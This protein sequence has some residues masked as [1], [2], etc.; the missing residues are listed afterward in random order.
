VHTCGKALAS[1]GAFVAGS[2][3]L[4]RFLI[5][6][7]R[8]FIFSTALPPYLAFQVRAAVN[9]AASMDAERRYLSAMAAQLR[10]K[11]RSLGFDHGRSGSHIVPLMVPGNQAALDMALALRERGCAVRAIRPPTVPPG[12]ERLR[13]SLT[14]RLVQEDLER[15][16]EALLGAHLAYG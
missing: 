15:F 16:A 10:R 4:K 11:L 13:L 14:V 3:V 5:N 6:H 9:L 12:T 1:A 2:V 7:A 8:S